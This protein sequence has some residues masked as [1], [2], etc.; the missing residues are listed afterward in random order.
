MRRALQI[1]GETAGP[2]LL[3][4]A[5]RAL[6]VTFR[7]RLFGAEELFARWRRGE[8][9]IV[10]FWHN[11]LVMMPVVGRG[12]KICIM[13]SG[14][15][16]G[17][18]ASR[19]IERWGIR[20]VSGSATRG[21]VKG[22]LSLVRVFREG[23]SLAVVP[24]GP[25]GPSQQAKPGIV[26]LAKATGADIFPVSYAADRAWRLRSW[27]RLIIPKPFAHVAV[28]VGEP[29]HVARDSDEHRLDSLRKELED[30]LNGLGEKAA[31]A[32]E[33]SR[34]DALPRH[35]PPSRGEREGEPSS[36]GSETSCR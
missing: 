13:N 18:I 4:A 21:G 11:R 3:S 30:R 9:V 8:K 5:L 6:A 1:F 35:P 19:A 31:A 10:A 28:A 20:T 22:F 23:Y 26:H 15:R 36:G 17:R 32:L 2:A 24:D 16:D 34:F 33:G 25:R 27:D 7:I 29:I 14:H 12:Q